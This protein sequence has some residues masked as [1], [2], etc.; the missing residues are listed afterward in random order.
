MMRRLLEFTLVC[1]PTVAASCQHLPNVRLLST[2]VSST[3]TMFSSPHDS[4]NFLTVRRYFVL[5]RTTSG[6]SIKIFLLLWHFLHR[7]PIL[8]KT[9]CS[10]SFCHGKSIFSLSTGSSFRTVGTIFSMR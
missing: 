2:H 7:N 8:L 1:T 4:R 10:E 6:R 3:Y 9:R 5:H